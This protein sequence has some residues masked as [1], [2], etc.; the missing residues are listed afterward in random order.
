MEKYESIFFTTPDW[1]AF[2]AFRK[3]NKIYVDMVGLNR[4]CLLEDMKEK[5]PELIERIT[6]YFEK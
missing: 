5:Y 6:K 1:Q 2:L 3:N 4:T